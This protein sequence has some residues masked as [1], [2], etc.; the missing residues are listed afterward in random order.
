MQKLIMFNGPPRSGKD[1]SFQI[2]KEL[3]KG[4]SIAHV[5]FTT[6]V[7]EEAHRRLGLNVDPEHFEPQKDTPLLEFGGHTPR[8]Y[9]KL[10][11]ETMKRE[12]GPHIVAEILRAE[13][14]EIDAD[15]I[16]NT[17]VGYDFEAEALQQ[18]I[19]SENTILIRLHRK[20]K[21]FQGDC[22]EWAHLEGSECYDVVN[23]DRE[24]FKKVLAEIVAGHVRAPAQEN[25]PELCPAF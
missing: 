2:C 24:A 6:V 25:E 23:N 14:A 19:G 11:S 9:Y 5:K 1:T 18:E 17:D 13:V 10:T 22:R 15:I 20:G 16:I 21:S 12:R 7:K 4:K 8:D 3:L